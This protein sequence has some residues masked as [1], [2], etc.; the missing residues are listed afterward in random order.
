MLLRM[1]PSST[2]SFVQVGEDMKTRPP[3]GALL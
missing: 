3:G 1:M 2:I